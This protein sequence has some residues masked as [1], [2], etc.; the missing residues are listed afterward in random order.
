MN[1]F[2]RDF[3]VGEHVFLKVK[4]KRSSLRIGSFS[5][6]TTRYCGPFEI[7]E[8]IWPVAYMLAFPA[9]M[10]VHNVFHLSLLNKYVPDPNHIVDWNVIQVD[11]EGVFW[12]EPVRIL[13]RK[14]KVFR[15]M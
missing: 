5:K 10:R 15:N 6:S 1:I 14:V 12:V 7:L 4:A 13:D 9:S 8:K 11:R 2:F 3:K